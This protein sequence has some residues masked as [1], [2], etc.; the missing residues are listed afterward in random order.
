[1][2][3]K[4]R[5]Q[6]PPREPLVCSTRGALSALVSVHGA[7][8]LISYEFRLRSLHMWEVEGLLL[9]TTPTRAEALSRWPRAWFGPASAGRPTICGLG[10]P[11]VRLPNALVR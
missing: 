11:E 5:P 6:V 7:V 2:L 4:G 10:R 9:E 3:W 1:M 8:S